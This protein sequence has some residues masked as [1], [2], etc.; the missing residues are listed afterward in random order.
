M[1]RQS[2]QFGQ[3]KGALAP[4]RMSGEVEFDDLAFV[5]TSFYLFARKD[6]GTT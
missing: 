5:F 4:K 6:C 3:K 1:A 2:A